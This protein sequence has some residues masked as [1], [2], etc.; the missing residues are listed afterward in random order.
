M[1]NSLKQGNDIKIMLMT[2]GKF[3]N[4]LLF[5]ISASQQNFLCEGNFLKE[6]V[7]VCLTKRL[8]ANVAL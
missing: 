7:R 6:K 8:R 2:V 3:I 1:S 5:S 4:M